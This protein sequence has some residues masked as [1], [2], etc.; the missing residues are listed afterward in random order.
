[1]PS[2]KP[3]DRLGPSCCGVRSPSEEAII[4]AVHHVEGSDEFAWIGQSVKLASAQDPDSKGSLVSHCLPAGFGAY[5][6]WLHPIYEDLSVHDKNLTW[7]DTEEARLD[8]LRPTLPAETQRTLDI[9]R[10]AGGVTRQASPLGQF[11]ARRV[12]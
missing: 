5:A 3:S 2:A 11:P 10:S 7:H 9:I 6:K 1:M 8:R 12:L 4:G